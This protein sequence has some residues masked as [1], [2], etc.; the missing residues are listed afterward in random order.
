MSNTC[1]WSTSLRDLCDAP[2]CREWTFIYIEKCPDCNNRCNPKF[3][4][5]KPSEVK[6]LL[7]IGEDKL[8]IADP[9]DPIAKS[10]IEKLTW[11]NGIKISSDLS[12]WDHKVKICYEPWSLNIKF[13]DLLDWPWDYWQD[14]CWEIDCTDEPDCPCENTSCIWAV[15]MPKCDWTW[16][17]WR[18]MSELLIWEIWTENSRI[19]YQ[20]PAETEWP[21]VE[22]GLEINAQTWAVPDAQSVYT[23]S[24]IS[25]RI[26]I[27]K[28]GRY[29]ID[30]QAQYAVNKYLN[31]VRF[32]VYNWTTWQEIADFKYGWRLNNW[33]AWITWYDT[34]YWRDPPQDVNNLNT[35][36]YMLNMFWT[37]QLNTH[38]RLEPW[39]YSLIMKID[40]RTDNTGTETWKIYILWKN[41]DTVINE[42]RWAITFLRISEMSKY[43]INPCE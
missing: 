28:A 7:N 37:A 8:V 38:M 6:A 27:T 10:L 14:K 9:D 5:L 39:E 2:D 34:S 17:E 43:Y 19:E 29:Q 42:W 13:T 4:L 40:T 11:C 1:D 33:Y 36:M 15:L 25:Q 20:L 31:A 30:W 16:V 22:L 35:S 23:S 12:W 32:W 18:C 21:Q 41:W 3:K 24:P 26:V